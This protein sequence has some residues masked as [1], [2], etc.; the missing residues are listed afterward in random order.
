MAVAGSEV[1][2]TQTASQGSLPWRWKLIARLAWVVAIAV[3][4]LVLA[5]W[6]WRWF[7]PAPVAMPIVAPS[8]DLPRRI[9]E[10]GLFGVAAAGPANAVQS[11]T[12]DLKLLGVFAQRDG[13]GY[14]LFRAGARGPLLIAAGQDIASG[15]QL[16]SVRPDG[17]TLVDNGQR[18]SM[19]LRAASAPEKRLPAELLGG[20][21]AAPDGW[22]ALLEPGAGGLVVRDQGGFAGMLGLRNGDRVETANGIA[23]AIPDDIASTV[24][25]PLTRSQPVWVSGT[26]GGKPQQWLYLNAGACP[27]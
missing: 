5:H 16:E 19:L 3:L 9:A 4:A 18:R 15:V 1:Y 26:R 10:A 14:A 23:L 24:L 13:Q 20:M 8:G 6:I 11:F 21:T 25:Q 27:A 7:G 17:V 2:V 22:K 12:G